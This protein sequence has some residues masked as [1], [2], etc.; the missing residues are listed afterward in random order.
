MH[1]SKI[2]GTE[3]SC[4]DS[5]GFIDWNP[6]F[7]HIRKNNFWELPKKWLVTSQAILFKEVANNNE[8]TVCFSFLCLIWVNS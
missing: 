5:F 2:L 8:K 7:S 3:L 6:L 4:F 1:L